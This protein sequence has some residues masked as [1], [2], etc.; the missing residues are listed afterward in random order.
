MPLLLIQVS[1][2]VLRLLL[3]LLPALYNHIIDLSDT[4]DHYQDF[5]MTTILSLVFCI[6]S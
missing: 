1:Q 3:F 4:P 5:D 6:I 2:S